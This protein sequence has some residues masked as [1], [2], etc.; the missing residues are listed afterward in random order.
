MSYEGYTEYLCEKGH[1]FTVDAMDDWDYRPGQGH[2]RAQQECEVCKGKLAFMASVDETN[3][4]DPEQ[5]HT[6][7]APRV[8]YAFE[9]LPCM[10]RFGNKYY[11]FR[12]LFAPAPGSR[13]IKINQEKS[14]DE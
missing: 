3:G 13:W 10:D 9:D 8:Q 5:P 12:P 7:D 1:Y 2:V 14:D 6:F 4:V 11:A